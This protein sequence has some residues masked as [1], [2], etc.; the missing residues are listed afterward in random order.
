MS[1]SFCR[2]FTPLK[3]PEK[4]AENYIQVANFIISKLESLSQTNK[5]NLSAKGAEAKMVSIKNYKTKE[6]KEAEE[7]F[8][9]LSD[10][11]FPEKGPENPDN[12]A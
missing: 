12:S 2:Y 6:Q 11:L 10:H 3:N 8:F 4:F 1:A 7:R 5:A 9:H